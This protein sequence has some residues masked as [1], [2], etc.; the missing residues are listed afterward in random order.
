MPGYEVQKAVKING[1]DLK[2][3]MRITLT[4]EEAE[5]HLESLKEAPPIE[6]KPSPSYQVGTVP[7]TPGRIV[8]YK[9]NLQF[10]AMV[11]SVKEDGTVNLLVAYERGWTPKNGVQQG[12]DDGMWDWMPFQKDQQARLAK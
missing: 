1:V 12:P 7:V 9:D 6:E 10:P 5:P 8:Y 11:V 4:P 3:G 2:P